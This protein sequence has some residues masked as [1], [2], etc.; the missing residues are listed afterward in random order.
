MKYVPCALASA[1]ATRYYC[2]YNSDCFRMLKTNAKIKEIYDTRDG[3]TC[4]T[5]VVACP[6]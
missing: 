4:S 3:S 2:G 5:S 1:K 6:C